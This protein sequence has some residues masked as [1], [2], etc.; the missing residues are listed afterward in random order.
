MV[1]LGVSLDRTARDATSYLEASGSSRLVALWGSLA[2][3]RE[4]ARVYGIVGIPHTFVIDR[5]GII[6][7]A[8]HPA[9]LSDALLESCL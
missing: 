9:R 8:D 4:V 1:L 6:R 2:Q 3:A 7:F 5:E